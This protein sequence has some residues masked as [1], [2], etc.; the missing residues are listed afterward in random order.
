MIKSLFQ[1][2]SNTHINSLLLSIGSIAFLLTFRTLKKTFNTQKYESKCKNVLVI[3]IKYFPSELI[4]VIIGILIVYF[5][6][7]AGF[8]SIGDIPKGLP[9]FKNFLK[10]IPS[11]L[12]WNSGM[13]LTSFLIAILCFIE[14]FVGGQK[15]ADKLE[16][17]IDAS[18]EL[19]ALGVSNIVMSWFQCFISGGALSRTVVV[20]ESGAL[21][22]LTGLLCGIFMIVA[23]LLLLPVFAF[24]PKPVLGSIVV[25]GV[26]GLFDFGGMKHLWKIN[27]ADFMIMFA[28]VIVTLLLGIDIG[29]GTGVV[30]S[31]LIFLKHSAKPHYSVLGR[32]TRY[33]EY[34][35]YSSPDD[36]DNPRTHRQKKDHY[37]VYKDIKYNKNAKLRRDMLMIRWDAPIFFGNFNSFKSRINKQIYRFLLK[38]KSFL[39]TNINGEFCLCLSFESVT[40]MDTTGIDLLYNFFVELKKKY[41]I[42]I[43]ISRIKKHIHKIFNKHGDIIDII[44]KTNIV[45][46]SLYECE[47]IWNK[48]LIT[49]YPNHFK[50]DLKMII[51]PSFARYNTPSIGDDQRDVLAIINNKTPRVLHTKSID[52]SRDDSTFIYHH[53]YKTDIHGQSSRSDIH[54]NTGIYPHG[55]INHIYHESHN[56]SSSASSVSSPRDDNTNIVTSNPSNKNYKPTISELSNK[57][58]TELNSMH[59]QIMDRETDKLIEGGNPDT[60]ILQ[61]S[62]KNIELFNQKNA[63]HKHTSNDDT[64]NQSSS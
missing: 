56:A 63:K 58:T 3:L 24:I 15:Y 50:K 20:G 39:N 36:D 52:H 49:K 9:P 32:I 41:S 21:T 45:Y 16:Y 46:T 11:K 18:Q 44:G 43:I 61:L 53:V 12:F 64:S 51:K 7:N 54:A 14:S 26:L 59:E 13:W 28:T 4:M 1:N 23:I 2:I 8:D 31:I 57:I 40:D 62:T 19:I 60:A 37:Y 42:F 22:P 34:Q 33:N 5:S 27:R 35:N 48:H 17:N 6:D 29:V 10:L 30:L 55:M 47:K 38:N 25:V